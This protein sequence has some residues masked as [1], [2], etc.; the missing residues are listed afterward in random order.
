MIVITECIYYNPSIGKIYDIMKNAKREHNDRYGFNEDYK[1]N[2]KAKTEFI[3]QLKNKI[4]KMLRIM[5]IMYWV[6]LREEKLH[7]G[8][9]TRLI[10]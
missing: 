2:V 3:D 6:V 8:I 5:I 1:V 4:K 10:K 7:Q 9:D